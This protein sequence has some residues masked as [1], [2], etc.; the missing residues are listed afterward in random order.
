M[1]GLPPGAIALR[2]RGAASKTAS[3][4]SELI[5]AALRVIHDGREVVIDVPL[6]VKRLAGEVAPATPSAAAD[7][8][9]P[10]AAGDPSTAALAQA[11]SV[12]ELCRDVLAEAPPMGGAGDAASGG[13]G[14]FLLAL[15]FAF[16]GGLV[17]NVM[18]CVL[19]VLSLKVMSLV[20]Q[21]GSERRVIWRHGLAYTAGVLAS[22][23]VFAASL[24]GLK[25]TTWGFQ[26]QDPLFVA[27]FGAIV[28]AMA[29][30]LFGV[31]EITLPGANRIDATV[32]Q[33]HG[34]AS[35]FAYGIFAV[36][37]GT[38]CTAPLLGPAMAYAF[39]QPPLEL[40]LLLLTVGLGLAFPFLL[41]AA[42]P[43]WQRVLPKPGPWLET[44]KKI[45]GFLLVGTTVYLLYA[46]S[47]QISRGALVGYV[48][49]LSTVALALWVYGH[50]GG[51]MRETR[52]R[53]MGI[54]AAIG[55][56]AGGV[57][58]FGSL[59]PP[60]Q[61]KGTLEIGGIAWHD[62][63]QVDVKALAA[64]GQ[65][66]FI[67]FTAE[68]CATCKVNEGTA[69][70]TDEVRHAFALLGVT[71]VKADFTVAKPEIAKWLKEFQE[72]SVPLYVV[73]PA[74]RPEG[75]IK[76]PTLLSTRD[77]VR[78]VCQAGASRLAPPPAR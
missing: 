55:L 51:F 30:S 7:P 17:L 74:G 41:L 18:P 8:A 48:A 59:E 33:S 69:I 60:P 26:M 78:G 31:Y 35:S 12:D 67:D 25:V 47:G 56:V 4:A 16:V 9:S 20:E 62:F 37:L 6:A 72:P 29:L 23:G 71:P 57:H 45:M 76:L 14:S 34:Y 11:A 46:L 21:N 13:P 44:F 61:H 40:T 38:P 2:V 64:A 27:I 28:F 15:L 1:A 65:T 5:E 36:L 54:I 42:F 52:T 19:P 22:F 49:V 75:A 43:Q 70:Y 58:L 66:V 53:V 10:L 50:W 3:Q 77:V 39:T 24:V 63:D 32:R 73:L 68:W